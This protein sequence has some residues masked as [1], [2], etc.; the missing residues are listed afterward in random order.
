MLQLLPT[1][2]YDRKRDATF[3][4]YSLPLALPVFNPTRFAIEISDASRILVRDEDAV[5]AGREGLVGVGRIAEAVTVPPLSGA[6]V[7][8]VIDLRGFDL[9]LLRANG[10]SLWVDTQV[11]VRVM[12]MRIHLNF[13]KAANF[14]VGV[15]SVI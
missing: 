14:S 2:C 5:A 10:A 3:F 13:S 8:L 15:H 1:S 6:S 12:G 7:G 4:G 11:Q 9:D